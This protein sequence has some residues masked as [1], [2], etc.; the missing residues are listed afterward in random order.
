MN[1]HAH[2]IYHFNTKDEMISFAKDKYN[3]HMNSP[4]FMMD[5]SFLSKQYSRFKKSL[6]LIT[7]YYAIKS[8]DN[9]ILIETLH[10]LGCGF[11]CA[12]INEILLVKS[13]AS[14]TFNP[15]NIIF[16]NPSKHIN[17]IIQAK[18]NA[19]NTVTYDSIEELNKLK[20][21]H[22]NAKLVLR[23]H[24]ND[25]NSKVHLSEIFGAYRDTWIPLI[26]RT[27]E[28]NMNLIGICFHVGSI[29]MEPTVFYDALKDCKEL[30]DYCKS[31]GI[32]L[33]LL[34]IGG[35]FPSITYE[36]I[37][38]NE[39]LFE[40]FANEIN[41]GLNMFFKEEITSNKIRIIAEP[42]R[43]FSSGSTYVFLKI[44][45]RK[46]WNGVSKET[47]DIVKEISCY[48][49]KEKNNEMN[50][51]YYCNESTGLSLSSFLYEDNKEMPCFID[52]D[53]DERKENENE[54][55]NG[56]VIRSKLYG[57]SSCKVDLIIDELNIKEVLP[58]G[59][60]FYFKN[61]GAYSVACGKGVEVNGV[62]INENNIYYFEH[63]NEWEDN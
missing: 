1:K 45:N 27:I 62:K 34:D 5:L 43:F 58:V 28:L 35:G 37:Y 2:T 51:N 56:M 55:E 42:G 33:T 50:I 19:I 22:P 11:D 60:K 24:V 48:K 31:K 16:A 21:H 25:A 63:K 9:P 46:I 14:N 36:N 61:L 39:M 40:T 32:E 13:I 4:F 38:G 17:H 8:N 29:S 44:I 6:P 57:F 3:H 7:P 30:F 47:Q 26:T 59:T 41:K 52:V 23:I 10:N 49:G 15:D 18:A 54:K 53:V 12:S 20:Q